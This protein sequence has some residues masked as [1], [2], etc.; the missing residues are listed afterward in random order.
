MNIVILIYDSVR[1]DFLPVNPHT[2]VQAPTIEKFARES[3]NFREAITSAPWTLPSIAAIIGGIYSHKLGLYTWTQPYPNDVKTL[4]HYLKVEGYS[5]GTFVFD[6]RYLFSHM[7]FAHVV[8]HS[9]DFKKVL[10]WIND[11]SNTKF[12]LFYHGWLTHIP[13]EPMNSDEAWRRAVREI[14]KKLRENWQDAVKWCKT[15]YIKA[16]EYVSEH[17]I[18]QLLQL[19]EERDILDETLIFLI[20]DHGESWGERIEDKTQI[21]VNFDLHGRFLYDENIK[22]MM[23]VKFPHS[24]SKGKTIDCQVRSVD[25]LPTILELLGIPPSSTSRPL[26]GRSLLPVVKGTDTKRIAVVS[27]TGLINEDY[28]PYIAK[29]AIRDFPYKLI[30]DF[31][32]DKWEFYDLLQD[33]YEMTNLYN[34]PALYKKVLK[35]KGLLQREKN[36]I[37]SHMVEQF[38]KIKMQKMLKQLGYL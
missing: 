10:K 4:F 27:T 16:I 24:W 8:D 34:N 28:A 12:L 5:I 9:R 36:L 17:E 29:M 35:L 22:I 15:K 19:L 7:P 3:V 31:E 13:W 37:P 23:L 21:R 1:P 25:I 20:S 6:T 14:H 32:E 26:D 38:E 33:P 18:K 30:V 2:E 11:H